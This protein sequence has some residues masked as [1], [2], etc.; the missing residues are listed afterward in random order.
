MK[1]R[2][3]SEGPRLF[4]CNLLFCAFALC[5]NNVA[6]IILIG[7]CSD[8]NKH[9][10]R[11]VRG[12]GQNSEQKHRTKTFVKFHNHSSLFTMVESSVTLNAIELPTERRGR[13]GTL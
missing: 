3:M 10:L 7:W 1:P 6:K 8:R 2:F 12:Q 5:M 9:L 4:T 11:F 13:N